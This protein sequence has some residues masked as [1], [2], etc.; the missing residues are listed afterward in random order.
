MFKS[1]HQ[2]HGPSTEKLNLP[3]IDAMAQHALHCMVVTAR[4]RGAIPFTQASLLCSGLSALG[5][6]VAGHLS[7]SPCGR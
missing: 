7:S 3:G 6:Y 2:R 1:K 5:Q 4:T